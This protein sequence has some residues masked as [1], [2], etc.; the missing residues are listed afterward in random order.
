MAVCQ[1]FAW[2]YGGAEMFAPFF[3]EVMVHGAC[4][5]FSL[6]LLDTPVL[7]ECRRTTRMTV[8]PSQDK[9]SICEARHKGLITTTAT[10][11][12]RNVICLMTFLECEK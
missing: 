5:Y 1:R 4:F 11:H 7:V 6:W 3:M 9:H 2:K 10:T 8:C 12:Y